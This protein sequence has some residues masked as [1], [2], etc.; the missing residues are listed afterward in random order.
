[1]GDEHH[2]P[3][4][5]SPRMIQYPLYRR[6]GVSYGRSVRVRKISPP[7]GFDSR[8]VQPI[9]SCYTNY[10]IPAHHITHKILTE[11]LIKQLILQF[12]WNYNEVCNVTQIQVNV[13]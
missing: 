10:A 11:I 2:A 3:A 12:T 6:L 8:T 13:L 4:A 1:V 5:L 9:P 7:T